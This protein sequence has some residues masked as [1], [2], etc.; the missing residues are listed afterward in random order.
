[1]E[2]KLNELLEHIKGN[3]VHLYNQDVSLDTLMQNLVDKGYK[4]VTN[5]KDQSVVDLCTISLVLY[6]RRIK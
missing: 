6:L 3:T 4:F 1:M 5:P 2:K